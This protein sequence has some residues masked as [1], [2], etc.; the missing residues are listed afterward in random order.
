MSGYPGDHYDDGYGYNHY[1]HGDSYYQDDNPHGYYD[2]NEYGDGYYDQSYV[3]S[4]SFFC[5]FSV[6]MIDL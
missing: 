3:P 2:P 1:G 4:F 5:F 6:V